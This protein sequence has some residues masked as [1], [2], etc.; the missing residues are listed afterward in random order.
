MHRPP[1][2]LLCHGVA[3]SERRR[4]PYGLLL[5][6]GRLVNLIHKLRAWGYSVVS[7]GDLARLVLAG[8][9]TGHAALTFDDGFANNFTTLVPILDRLGAT[10]T[11]FVCTEWL[12]K[13][14]RDA[15][16]ERLLTESE[17]RELSRAGVEI[18]AHT[19]THPDLTK[20]P[21]EAALSEMAMS[22]HQLEQIIGRDV[23]V[24]AYP[25]GYATKETRRAC[26]EAGFEAACR[27]TSDGTWFDAY[28]LP[29]QFI[30][31]D[32]TNFGFY[33]KRDGRYER[34]MRFPPARVI[35]KVRQVALRHLP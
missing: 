25:Y 17:V 28:D 34:L 26:A 23:T 24:F 14:H 16:A 9:A 1:F 32:L 31:N 7:F 22:K 18:G 5:S 20:L 12:G 35:R 3:E 2:I 27:A 6:P 21:Y 13:P 30:D 11:V 29:R 8:R 4:D 33:L 10:A 15:P 19:V